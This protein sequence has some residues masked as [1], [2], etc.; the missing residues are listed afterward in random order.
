MCRVRTHWL[1]A[2]MLSAAL[3]FA[4]QTARAQDLPRLPRA[5]GPVEP[6]YWVGLSYGVMDG[7]TLNDGA[8]GNTWQFGYSQVIRAAVEKRLARGITAGVS[9]A[10][11]T[12]SLQYVTQGSSNT[13]CFG[14]CDAKA[15][16]TQYLAFIRGGGGLGFHGIYNLDGGVTSYSNFRESTSNSALPPSSATY[17]FTFGFGG[18]LGYGISSTSEVYVAEQTYLILHSQGQ[19]SS[20][21]NGPHVLTFAAGVRIGF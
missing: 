21:S 14:V 6:D 7:V 13:A 18:G 16:I 10:Y 9:A 8:T 19:S 3:A 12:A 11:S 4:S 17:D 15:D 20:I 1:A 5:A 2:A